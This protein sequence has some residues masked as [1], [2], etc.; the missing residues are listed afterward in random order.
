MSHLTSSPGSLSDFYTSGVAGRLP[1]AFITV[2][3]KSRPF[4]SLA[5]SWPAMLRCC[6]GF[7]SFASFAFLAF[8]QLMKKAN[9][10]RILGVGIENLWNTYGHYE[11]RCINKRQSQA[12]NPKSSFT[13]FTLRTQHRLQNHNSKPQSIFSPVSAFAHHH[14]GRPTKSQHLG[15]LPVRNGWNGLSNYSAM[16]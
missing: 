9:V 11:I 2:T 4:Q 8:A 16:P 15:L 14:N 3:D 1:I 6:A 13:S 12:S 10:W 7:A 5:E